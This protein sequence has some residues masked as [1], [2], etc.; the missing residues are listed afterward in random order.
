MPNSS[1]S[2]YSECRLTAKDMKDSSEKLLLQK[3]KDAAV[4]FG[5][6]SAR[7]GVVLIQLQELY[8]QQGRLEDAAKI[9]MRVRSVL[10]SYGKRILLGDRSH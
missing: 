5:P 8:E 3:L 1:N 2:K 9:E 7:A 10:F 6:H 4:S